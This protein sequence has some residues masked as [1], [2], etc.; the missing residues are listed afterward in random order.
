MISGGALTH[1]T[2]K[3]RNAAIIAMPMMPETKVM[4]IDVLPFLVRPRGLGSLRRGCGRSR[5]CFDKPARRAQE[6]RIVSAPADE[7]HAERQPCLRPQ[8]R[9][10]HGRGAEIGPDGAEDRIAG[11]VEAARRF[12][13]RRRRQDRVV[14]VEHRVERLVERAGCR[15]RR[16]YSRPPARSRP[17]SMSCAQRLRSAARRPARS[18]GG[19]C[20]PCPTSMT[21]RCRSMAL[22]EA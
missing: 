9:Q 10:R 12:A 11:A 1:T 14:F 21:V 15:R 22:V 7:L 6:P 3:P 20:A 2:M 13:R 17:R 18:R 16:A 8:Q 5:P 4:I 19:D